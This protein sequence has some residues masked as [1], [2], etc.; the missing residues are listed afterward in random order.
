MCV[1]SVCTFACPNASS[2]SERRYTNDGPTSPV[3][4]PQMSR[5]TLLWI[6]SLSHGTLAPQPHNGPQCTGGWEAGQGQGVWNARWHDA[7]S[8]P[9]ACWDMLLRPCLESGWRS[10]CRGFWRKESYVI[11]L[12]GC[13]I[14]QYSFKSCKKDLQHWKGGW[15]LD[16]VP[17]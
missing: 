9:L 7:D 15:N 14:L 1:T 10:V 11:A 13:C 6:L 2:E 3:R 5:T 12:G 17:T 8:G 4:R 16:I